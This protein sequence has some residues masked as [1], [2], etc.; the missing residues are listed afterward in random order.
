M[1]KCFPVKKDIY[2]AK[3]T[4]YS[5]LRAGVCEIWGRIRSKNCTIS[6]IKAGG[7]VCGFGKSVHFHIK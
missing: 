4:Y 1:E 6:T 3:M 5:V 7:L 2:T